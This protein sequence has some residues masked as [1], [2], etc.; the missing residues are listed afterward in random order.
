MEELLMDG[1]KSPLL[2]EQPKLEP[3]KPNPW[4]YLITKVDAGWGL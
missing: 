3:G 2:P 4:L 1:P